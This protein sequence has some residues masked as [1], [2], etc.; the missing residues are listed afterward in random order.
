MPR[1]TVR[2]RLTLTY[3]ALV[4]GCTVALTAAVYLFMRYV[5]AYHVALA[6]PGVDSGTAAP[7]GATRVR[8][9]G[10]LDGISIAT[11]GDFLNTLLLASS[12]AL[13]LLTAAGVLA[14]W[15]MA[16]RIVRPL[17]TINAAATRAATGTLDHRIAL[18]GP[19]D[20]IRDLSDTFDRMLA[21]LE[22]SF[23]AHRRFAA[24][25]SHELRTPLATTKTMLDVALDDPGT[26]AAAFRQ[27]AERLREV[28]RASIE[29]VDALLDLA[30]AQSGTTVR[31]PVDLAAV[32]ASAVAELRAEASAAA[33]TLAD[34]AGAA[35]AIGDPVLLRQAVSNL[36][37]NAIRHNHAGGRAAI[38][39][40]RAGRHARV[41]V[42]NTG[43]RVP[44][45]AVAT[46]TEPFTRAAG[47]ALTRGAGHG[48]GLPLVAAVASAH[49]AVLTLLPNP[50]GGLTVLLDLPVPESTAR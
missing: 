37:R 8:R 31:E 38:V 48:L 6:V 40:H 41:T 28:N 15:I 34:P 45:S 25:A 42:T 30:D 21:S 39:L 7:A 16:G 5:P 4:A 43:P 46:L 32:A 47:R 13:V 29:T 11:A 27:L 24:N 20:E 14:G 36:L 12:G 50:S 9:L 23:A 49:D 33:V 19:R 26:D 35:T 3:A 22:R 44:E 2:A 10:E 17:A 18:S 1:L